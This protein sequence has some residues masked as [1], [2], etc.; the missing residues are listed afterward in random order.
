[1]GLSL[2]VRVA[3]GLLLAAVIGAAVDGVLWFQARDLNRRIDALDLPG[4]ATTEAARP[5]L[6]FAAAYRLITASDTT[7]GSDAA[8][9]AIRAFRA[10][11][12]DTPLGQAARYNAANALLRQA[13]ELRQGEQAGQSIALIELAKETY[14]E[15]LRHDPADWDARY[16]LERAQR[17]LPDPE[18]AEPPPAGAPQAAERA[19]TTM[20]GISQGLP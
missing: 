17:L 10:L 11:Q 4:D 8:Q 14:R 13:V 15:V 3:A 12:G 16:N 1:M 7:P 20:R 6:R 19:A 5:Q 18:E 9:S 2:K